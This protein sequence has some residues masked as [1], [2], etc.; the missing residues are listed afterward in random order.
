M[1]YFRKRLTRL[2]HGIPSTVARGS[3][4]VRLVF[5]RRP[6]HALNPPRIG[7][8]A[9]N[10]NDRGW[11]AFAA[12]V[13]S[14]ISIRR[15]M[16]SSSSSWLSTNEC[17]RLA[18]RRSFFRGRRAIGKY[19]KIPIPG[20][21]VLSRRTLNIFL[22]IS[23]RQLSTFRGRRLS[24]N[25][26][27][28]PIR[29]D[30]RHLFLGF[31]TPPSLAIEMLSSKR[32]TNF[33]WSFRRNWCANDTRPTEKGPSRGD[34]VIFV[35]FY[36]SAVDSSFL[37]ATEMFGTLTD[38]IS[39]REKRTELIVFQSNR[40]RTYYHLTNYQNNL[41]CHNTKREKRVTFKHFFFRNH[42]SF[43]IS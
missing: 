11:A 3:R 26:T 19:E 18:F 6:L 35:H 39:K 36:W 43:R 22:I 4:T 7:A 5:Y 25:S 27:N 32:C 1:L 30:A 37:M 24:V 15:V 9:M 34:C 10:R 21:Q 23:T 28:T 42:F 8:T 14:E 41:S 20:L 17:D 16:T 40:R 38:E 29:F 31:L 13:F 12:S 2:Y 33:C